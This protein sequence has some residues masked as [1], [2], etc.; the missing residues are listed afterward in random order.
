M[1]QPVQVKALPGCKL[2]IKYAGS[3]EGQIDLSD[4]CGKGVSAL[5]EDEQAF[6]QVYIGTD[7]IHIC[8]DSAYM[9]I[10]GRRPEDLLPNLV[11]EAVQAWEKARNHEPLAKIVPLP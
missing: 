10:T 9:T 11:T 1:F 8:P 2:W 7:E 3:T 6:E 5:W 4:L